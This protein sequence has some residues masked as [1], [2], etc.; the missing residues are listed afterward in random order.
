MNHNC[1]VSF[2]Q[3][4]GVKLAKLVGGYSDVRYMVEKYYD[5]DAIDSIEP[6]SE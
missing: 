3:F 2:K 1:K 6:L 4:H 5:Q